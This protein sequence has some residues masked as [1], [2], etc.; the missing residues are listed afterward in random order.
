MKDYRTIKL[1]QFE[2]TSGKVVVSDPCYKLGTWCMGTLENVKK[3][4]WT[5]KILKT[6]EGD[7]GNRV[8]ALIA[9]HKDKDFGYDFCK[10]EKQTFEVGVDSGQAGIFDSTGFKSDDDNYDDPN[11]WY[12]RVC[13]ITLA[14]CGAGIIDNSGVASSSGYGDGGYDCSVIKENGKIIAIMID[15]GL[16]QEEEED[17]DEDDEDYEKEEEEEEE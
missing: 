17:Y 8:A 14:D 16:L 12:R 6:N 13:E 1:G 2:I 9:T 15:F 5:A 7:W 10:W 4:K 3:G 11:S